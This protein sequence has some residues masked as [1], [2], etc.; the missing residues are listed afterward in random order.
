MR[1]QQYQAS[2]IAVAPW[3]LP[4][5]PGDCRCWHSSS[6]H[7]AAAGPGC[8]KMV[9]ARATALLRHQLS[10]SSVTMQQQTMDPPGRRGVR[11]RCCCCCC[12][13]GT[14]ESGAA[15]SAGAACS[16]GA[17]RLLL[18]RELYRSPVV[19]SPP[20]AAASHSAAQQEQSW[21][22]AMQV[23]TG[24][25]ASRHDS[26]EEG[27]HVPAPVTAQPPLDNSAVVCVQGCHEGLGAGTCA[28][29]S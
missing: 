20:A 6:D 27:M 4:Q 9:S 16:P 11:A 15:A 24:A 26:K 19:S 18:I 21:C 13:G 23:P 1:H 25:A 17:T 5:H 7:P 2:C 22:R 8:S 3:R 28:S 10:L 14:R 12:G 29:C